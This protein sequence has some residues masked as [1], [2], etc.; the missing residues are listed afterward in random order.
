MANY[1]NVGIMQSGGSIF[2]EDSLERLEKELDSLMFAMNTPDLV[3]GTE[4]SLGMRWNNGLSLDVDPKLLVDTL[5]GKVSERLGALAKKYQIYFVPGSMYEYSTEP[6]QPTLYNSIP[7]FAPSGEMIDVYRKMCPYYPGEEFITKGEKYV[8]FDIP[9]KNTKIGVM[10][11][12]DW[13]FPEISRNLTLM[14]AELM[15][16]P[17]VDPEGLYDIYKSVAITRAVENQAYFLSLN[18]VGKFDTFYSYGHSILAG[19]YGQT[20]YEAGAAEVS[21]SIPLDMDVVKQVRKYGTNNTE[22]LL[23]QLKFFNPPMPYAGKMSEAPIFRDL[24]DPDFNLASR[25]KVHI[26]DGLIANTINILR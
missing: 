25:K 24:P 2:Y 20:I 10:N 23:R 12:H 18:M 26:E 11:C 8:V 21:V 15:I 14:G 19:P 22:Q 17:A 7:I 6:G 5:P 4:M 13:S 1:L 16:R 3:V 9:E